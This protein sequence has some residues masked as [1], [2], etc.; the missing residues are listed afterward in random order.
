MTNLHAA[1]SL[2]MDEIEEQATQ[3]HA[4]TACRILRHRASRNFQSRLHTRLHT[5]LWLG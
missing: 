4:P 2:S 1:K 3:T 5:R